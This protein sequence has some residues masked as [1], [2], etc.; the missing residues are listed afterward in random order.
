MASSEERPALARTLGLPLLVLYGLGSTIGAGIYAL[1]GEIA[2]AAGFGAPVSFLLAC[3]V[4]TC[5]ACSFA[6][7]V[8][9]YPRAAGAALYVQHGFDSRRLA[10]LVGLLVVLSGVVSCAA[11]LNAFVGYLQELVPLGRTA[12]ILVT[13]L[14]LAALAAWGI[15]ES[16]IAA[17]L[18]T[19]VELGG[20]LLVIGLGA[21]SLARLPARWTEFAPGSAGAP[22]PGILLGVTLA[23]YAFIGFEDMVDVVEET[24]DPS[25]TMPRAILLTL[26]LTAIIYVLLMVSALLTLPPAALEASAAPLAALYTAHTG[27]EPVLISAIALVAITNGALIQIIMAS[28]VVYGLASR[29]Q[30]PMRLARVHPT[31]RTPLLATTVVTALVLT[32]AVSGRLGGLANAASL[33]MLVIFTL[34]N[35]A[36]WRLKGR[37]DVAPGRLSLPRAVPLVGALLSL[38]FVVWEIGALLAT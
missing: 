13:G 12:A 11:M 7:L 31:T 10:R 33:I 19:L 32:T 4:A 8:A 25:V 29:G 36:L 20:L 3:L 24:R 16:V 38:G 18:V 26:G 28:R 23:F 15:R 34:V 21:D 5:T 9:R 2:G 1:V 37:A 22:W 14:T 17:A 30:L 6:E 35:L 27:R